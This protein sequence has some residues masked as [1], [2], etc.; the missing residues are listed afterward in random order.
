M[1]FNIST[2]LLKVHFLI[3]IP[4]LHECT[5]KV[6]QH[7]PTFL[8]AIIAVAK[9]FSGHKEGWRKTQVITLLNQIFQK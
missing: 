6:F 9:N 5:T 4:I 1:I 2:G 7:K 8:L 3:V